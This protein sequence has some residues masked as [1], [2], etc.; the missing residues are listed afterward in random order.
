LSNRHR[1]RNS[2]LTVHDSPSANIAAAYNHAGADYGAYAD[3]DPALPFAFGG[4]HGHADRRIWALIERILIELRESGA[5]SI[6]VLDAGCGPGTWLRRIVARARLLGFEAITARGLDVARVQVQRAQFLARDLSEM[7]GVNLTFEVADLGGELREADA[8]VDLALCLYSVLNHLPPVTL[9]RISAE[10]ARVTCGRFITT[11]R[12]V[13]S[14]PSILVNSIENARQFRYD[15]SRDRCVIELCDGRHIDLDFHLFTASELRSY[16]VDLFDVEEVRGLDLFHNR[17]AP[18]PRWNPP[19]LAIDEEFSHEL[20]KL[21][22]IYATR[23]GFIERATHLLLV[24]NRRRVAA[25]NWPA[26]IPRAMEPG[27]ASRR[28]DDPYRPRIRTV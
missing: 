27:V 11:V 12:S 17:F 22:E 19:S 5:R 15:D 24:A 4:L 23:P 21:E 20:D 26:P 13:G 7:P 2:G 8:S 10:F 28:D 3:G 18:D 25:E 9:P 14:A 1:L 16:F 6:S